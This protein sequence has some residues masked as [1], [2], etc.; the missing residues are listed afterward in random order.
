MSLS[1][2]DLDDV[3][4]HSLD[5]QIDSAANA[6]QDALNNATTARQ[7]DRMNT[8]V[9]QLPYRALWHAQRH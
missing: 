8:V 6:A 2:S 3:A 4:Q 7:A 1:Q 5:V 9:S